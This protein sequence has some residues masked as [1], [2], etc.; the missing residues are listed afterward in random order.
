MNI[1]SFF[2]NADSLTIFALFL[3]PFSRA[4]RPISALVNFFPSVSFLSRLLLFVYIL[5]DFSQQNMGRALFIPTTIIYHIE[6]IIIRLAFFFLNFC[7]HMTRPQVIFFLHFMRVKAKE[8][9]KSNK[10]K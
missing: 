7:S 8:R 10:I 6:I 3:S 2:L 1:N 5:S 9:I 4:P